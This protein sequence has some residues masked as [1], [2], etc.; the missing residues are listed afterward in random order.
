M[1]TTIARLSADVVGV[2]VFSMLDVKDLVR[3]DSAVASM[4][5]RTTLAAGFPYVTI[6]RTPWNVRGCKKV[7]FL[8]WLVKRGLCLNQLIVDNHFREIIPL[9]V[10]SPTTVDT[11]LEVWCAH[12]A[13]M[14]ELEDALSALND[15]T[16]CMFRLRINSETAVSIR[17]AAKLRGHVTESISWNTQFTNTEDIAELVRGNH[18]IHDV[19]I[20]EPTSEAMPIVAS[21]QTTL[22]SVRISHGNMTDEQLAVLDECC[23]LQSICLF[24]NAGSRDKGVVALARGCTA[25]RSV[26]IDCSVSDGAI[27]ALCTYCPMLESL[28]ALRGYL[29]SS[30]LEGLVASG[31]PLNMLGIGWK[32]ASA[33]T[34]SASTTFLNT[35]V[36][37]MIVV[38]APP[39][40]PT[41]ELAL[42]LMTSLNSFLFCKEEQIIT[43][44]YLPGRDGSS[45]TPQLPGGAKYINA[46]AMG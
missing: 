35:L 1:W 30:A 28:G 33:P 20:E 10:S 9:L 22:L 7:A 8:H 13:H 31:A 15:S 43:P 44:P 19:S 4:E 16:Y 36:S 38:V 21:L 45:Y 12:Q 34:L 18:S 46:S 24:K 23:N 3:L 5:M 26:N 6:S 32:V 39:C 14:D 40:A 37:F 42:S 11:R 25:L 17:N 27:T 29:T 41:L 2:N